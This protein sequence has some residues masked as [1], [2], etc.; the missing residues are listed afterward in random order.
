MITALVIALVISIVINFVFAAI[1]KKVC[2]QNSNLLKECIY[3]RRA[4]NSLHEEIEQ[5][6]S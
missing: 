2:K 6:I 5:L 3:S 4:I 1:V